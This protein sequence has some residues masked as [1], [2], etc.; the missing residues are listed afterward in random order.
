M[1]V[2]YM[3]SSLALKV[4]YE[5]GVYKVYEDGVIPNSDYQTCDTICESVSEQTIKQLITSLEEHAY[6][7][8]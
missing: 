8:A 1:L 5:Y 4:N 7:K 3:S 2:L 6:T